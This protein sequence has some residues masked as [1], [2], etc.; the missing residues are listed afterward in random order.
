M[1]GDY[2]AFVIGFVSEYGP[3]VIFLGMVLENTIGLGLVFPGL[4][5]LIAGGYFAGT[6]ELG[7]LSVLLTAYA[8]TLVGD[9]LSYML[10]RFGL[11]RLPFLER[12]SG[13]LDRIEAAIRRSTRRFL[14]FFHFPVYSRMILPALLGILKFNLRTWLLLDAVGAALFTTTFILVGY[15]VGKASK[16]LEIAVETANYLQWAFLALFII[17]MGSVAISIW[18]L[19]KRR[20]SRA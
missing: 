6:G 5:I 4:I 13:D 1:I 20:P 15:F 18:R 8:G 10:G 7:L 17:W 11:L 12:I 9:N 16:A 3:V 19:F 14:V 2:V